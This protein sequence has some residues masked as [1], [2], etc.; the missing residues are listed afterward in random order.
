MICTDRHI[1]ILVFMAVISLVLYQ[2]GPGPAFSSASD[3]SS[4]SGV[5]IV[6]NE[7]NFVNSK[8]ITLGQIARIEASPFLKES[9]DKVVIG[10]SPKPDQIRAFDKTKI[11]ALVQGEKYLPPDTTVLSPKRIYV[12][13][14][15]QTLSKDRV[16]DYVTKSLSRYFDGKDYELTGFEV[17]GLNVY[18]QGEISFQARLSDMVDRRGRLSFFLDLLIDNE[19]VDRLTVKGSVAVYERVLHCASNR[20]KGDVISKSD[21]YLE[22]RNIFEL[23]STYLK[24]ISDIEHKVLN[25]KL[26][27]GAYL[28]QGQVSD[29][30]LV[31]KGDVVTLVAKNESLLIVTSGICME[32]GFENE[33]VKVENLSSGR[34]VRGIVRGKSKVEVVY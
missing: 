1:R 27:K 34:T 3:G 25:T 30:F 14:L 33:P 4:V 6:V 23:D 9:L 8:K 15:S 2:I 18:P 16:K 28:K 11:I 21:F 10:N 31:N 17:R 24:E 13:R 32:N 7:N 19:K 5:N 22:K 26:K 12:K 20:K 29:P